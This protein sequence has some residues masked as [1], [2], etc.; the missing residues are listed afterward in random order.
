MGLLELMVVY[1][2]TVRLLCDARVCVCQLLT[3]LLCLLRRA[4]RGKSSKAEFARF[5]RGVAGSSRLGL[6]TPPPVQATVS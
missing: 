1:A 4:Q 6:V 5:A 3:V 2:L